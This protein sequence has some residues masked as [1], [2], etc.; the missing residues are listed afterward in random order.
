M[1]IHI[2]IIFLKKSLRWS[3][4]L[5]FTSVVKVTGQQLQQA[6]KPTWCWAFATKP[7]LQ[8]SSCAWSRNWL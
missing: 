7:E 4:L 3:G 6:V 1:Y 5:M 8:A 2:H